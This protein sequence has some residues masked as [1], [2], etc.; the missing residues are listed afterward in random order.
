MRHRP[1]HAALDDAGTVCQV[2][3]SVGDATEL[4]RLHLAGTIQL[5]QAHLLI[6]LCKSFVVHRLQITGGYA[7]GSLLV[8][9]KNLPR[10][11]IL[12]N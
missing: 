2:M 5:D 6:F 10:R 7:R 3:K 8:L 4:K 9:H 11:P 1:L 12:P